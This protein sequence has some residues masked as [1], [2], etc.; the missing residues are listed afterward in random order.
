MYQF[1]F[2]FSATKY[3]L[4]MVLPS[5]LPSIAQS[6]LLDCSLFY[7]LGTDEAVRGL[8]HRIVVQ[9]GFWV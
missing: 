9:N 2:Y 8:R 4:N 6:Q 5:V 1:W 3:G 7:V